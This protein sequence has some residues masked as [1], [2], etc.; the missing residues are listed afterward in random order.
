MNDLELLILEFEKYFKDFEK[1]NFLVSKSPIGWH[2]DHSLKVI[3]NVTLAL[4][5]SDP[6]N[7]YFNFNLKRSIIYLRKKIPRGVGK[8]PKS[9]R[10]FD[11]ITLEDLQSQLK[12][13]KLSV[14]DLDN[15]HPKSNFQH[16]YFGRL[17]LKQT[18]FFLVLHSKHHLEIIKDIIK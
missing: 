10:S 12:N 1:Q 9:V 15:L 5:S 16:P 7:Y 11:K 6:E 13:V 2:L 18:R 17:N 3:N 4:K 8:A 14:R